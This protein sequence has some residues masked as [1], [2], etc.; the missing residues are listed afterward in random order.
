MDANLI[1]RY[2][3]PPFRNVAHSDQFELRETLR[4]VRAGDIMPKQLRP[5]NNIEVLDRVRYQ[6]G[7]VLQHKRYGYTAVIIG[8]DIECSMNSQWMVQNQIDTLD[9]GRHQ[10]FYHAL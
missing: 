8:W 7:Q 5:R 6:V 4:V 9:R 1:E 2:V 3:C 10:S